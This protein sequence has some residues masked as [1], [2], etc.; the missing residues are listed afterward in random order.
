MGGLPCIDSP[1]RRVADRGVEGRGAAD[2]FLG[3]RLPRAAVD[4]AGDGPEGR[5]QPDAHCAAN[6]LQRSGTSRRNLYTSSFGAAIY[7]G[8]SGEE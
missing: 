1:L 6:Y 8:R 5:G 2:R 3:D 7:E 4:V